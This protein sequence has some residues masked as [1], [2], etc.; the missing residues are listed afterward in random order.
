MNDRLAELLPWYV[1]GTLDPADRAW[2]EAELAGNPAQA[3]DARWLQSLQ[4]R[5]R[6]NEPPVAANVG[7]DRAMARIRSERASEA[8]RAAGPT[9][10]TRISGWFAG[11][12]MRPALGAAALVVI[13]AQGAVMLS[14]Y[15]ANEDLANQIRA[16]HPAVVAPRV[17]YLRVTFKP[18]AR[19]EDIR[20]AISEV[21]GWLVDGPGTMG[22]YFLR[23]PGATR[24]AAAA[25]KRN[26]AVADVVQVDRLPTRD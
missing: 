8:R 26:P 20:L 6:E 5:I 1:N 15:R 11:F 2:I 13:V 21:K 19:E 24:E 18:D 12:G 4:L 25:L 3:A 16:A 22:D 9:A 17:E 14:M 7:L 23:L 10:L